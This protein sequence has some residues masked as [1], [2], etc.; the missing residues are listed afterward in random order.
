MSIFYMYWILFISD[1]VQKV[2]MG[3]AHSRDSAN[4]PL[5]IGSQQ[6]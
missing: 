3:E 6:I 1:Q 4:F 5:D 2:R